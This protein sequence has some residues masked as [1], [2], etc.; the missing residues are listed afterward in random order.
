MNQESRKSPQSFSGAATARAP[1][2]VKPEGRRAV[3][4][5]PFADLSP[6]QVEGHF[7]EGVADEILH[8]LSR[9]EGL[10]L[11]S[12]TSSFIYKDSGLTAQ[13]IGQR[14]GVLDVLTGR[15]LRERERLLIETELID[16][17]SG[18]SIWYQCYNREHTDVFKV[19]EEVAS[20]VAL[21]L[22]LTMEPLEHPLP[23]VD[24]EVFD[25]YLKGR[26]HYFRYNRRGMDAATEQ[27]QQALGIDP[28]Y[29]AA[30]AGLANCAAFRYI[31]GDRCEANREQAETA[32][33]KALELDP[34]LAEAHASRG[35]ALSAAGRAEEAEKAFE[36][37]L[38]LDPFLYE[39]AYFYARH[40]FALGRMELAIQF[41]ERASAIRPEDC[42][43][44]LLVAQA[45][46]SLGIEDEATA[47]RERGLRLAEE[48]LNYVP[49][50]A[51]TRYLGANALV[52]LGH[53]E[54][55]L[56]WARMARELDPEDPMLLYNLGC[57]HAL[58]KDPDEAIECLEAAA[59]A[60]LTQKGWFLHDGDLDPL[61]ELPRFKELLQRLD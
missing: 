27:F 9:V 49:D 44:V 32:S 38:E 43:S 61:R 40:C 10:R 4:V 60:G 20:G 45:Y 29:A 46:T 12:R 41:F 47:A 15:C 59:S 52:S 39:A 21:T 7:C 35:A 54:R 42:Q 25:L 26:Q 23:K 17:T 18:H 5:L 36:K 33:M 57:I 14:L 11:L 31:Y 2:F 16:V 13:E 6:G 34:N 3:A 50:D 55:G 8:A 51:R 48:R 22:G 1:G 19:R 24:L 28:R 53:R 58:A 56:A 30:W 37:A